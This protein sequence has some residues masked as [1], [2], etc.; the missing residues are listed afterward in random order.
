MERP[1]GATSSKSPLPPLL[2][3]RDNR[4]GCKLGHSVPVR[5]ITLGLGLNLGQ[6]INEVSDSGYCIGGGIRLFA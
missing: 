3:G 1:L 2:P 6:S 5:S 4:S